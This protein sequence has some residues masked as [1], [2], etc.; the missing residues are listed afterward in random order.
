MSCALFK[1]K[2]EDLSVIFEAIEHELMLSELLRS[3]AEEICEFGIATN[4]GTEFIQIYLL[5]KS[6]AAINLVTYS[7]ANQQNYL[8]ISA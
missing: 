6:F 2:Q 7:M 8:N 4:R 5:K 3:M 1:V